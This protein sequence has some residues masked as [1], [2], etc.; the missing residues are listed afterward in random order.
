MNLVK[1]TLASGLLAGFTFVALP[2]VASAAPAV[3]MQQERA[4]HPEI[5]DAIHRLREAVRAL[6]AAPDDFGGN[7]G[8]A[9]ADA[10]RT[11]HSLKKA[12]YWR[13]RMDDAALERTE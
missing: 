5:V 2:T 12:L 8:A 4:A 6:E 11:I 10:H 1:K 9:I 3:T 7:K 13:L